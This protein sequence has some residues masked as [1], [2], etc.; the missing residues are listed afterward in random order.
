MQSAEKYEPQMSRFFTDNEA[1]E[2]C[3]MGM[4]LFF[5]CLAELDKLLF[6]ILEFGRHLRRDP[7]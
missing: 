3:W 7:E 1:S 6:N 5:L 4:R 2:S